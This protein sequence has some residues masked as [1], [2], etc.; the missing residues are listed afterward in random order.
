[1]TARLDLNARWWLWLALA[2]TIL[3]FWLVR[4]QPI[5]AIS[6]ATLDDR[7]CLELAQSLVRGEWLGTYNETTLAKG[8]GYPLFIALVFYLGIPLG[9]AQQALYAGACALFARALRPAFTLSAQVSVYLV[10]LWNPMSFEGPTLGRIMRQHLATPL[11]LIIFAGLV[12]LYLRRTMTFRHL[13]P[14]GALLGFSTGLFWLTREEGIWILPSIFLLLGAAWFGARQASP[15]AF[16]SMLGST[17]VAVVCGTMLL[18]FVCWQNYRHYGW[19]GTVELKSA[20]FQAAYGALQRVKIGPELPQVPVTRQAR[21]AIYPISPAFESLRPWLE[22]DNWTEQ[23]LFPPEDRQIRGGWMMW[24]LRE[25]VALSGRAT[26]AKDA[27][28]FYQT[29]ADEIHAACDSG[30]LPARPRRDTLMPPWREGQT[31][32]VARTFFKFADFVMAFTSF[33]AFPPLSIGDREELKLFHDLTGDA[34]TSSVR[35]P[36][37]ERPN[38]EALHRHKLELL[39]K[40]GTR[41]GFALFVAGIIAHVIALTRLVQSVQSRKLSYALVVAFAAWGGTA[42]FLLLNALVHVVSF[43]LIAVSTFSPV[44]PLLLIFYV[45]ICWDAVAVWFTRERN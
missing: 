9:L 29:L 10:L 36:V 37:I 17:L 12:A 18:T 28:R 8:A 22:R 15:G 1:M 2:L 40:I 11:G 4:A 34:L 27:L 25:S 42:S 31:A 45:A 24:A 6:N 21:E 38:R 5:F 35:A 32:A 3:K 44:Y 30:L 13:A 41:L 39:Q 43:P 26:S 16:R 23:E 7:L 33:N 20:E 19:F 14:W